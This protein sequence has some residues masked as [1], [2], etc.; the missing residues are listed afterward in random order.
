MSNQTNET[1]NLCSSLILDSIKSDRGSFHRYFGV[2]C[3][4]TDDR[5]Q[6]SDTTGSDHLTYQARHR[7]SRGQT[8][9]T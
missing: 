4:I 8:T 6:I 7:V 2:R 9:D 1:A 5:K 3:Q